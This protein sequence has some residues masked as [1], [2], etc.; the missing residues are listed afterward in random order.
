MSRS[1]HHDH[2]TANPELNICRTFTFSL[3]FLQFL[4]RVLLVSFVVFAHLS[5]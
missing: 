1:R 3:F 5:V 4:D 2:F